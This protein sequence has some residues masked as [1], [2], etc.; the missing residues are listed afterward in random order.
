MTI[1]TG[2]V[3]QDADAWIKDIPEH[4][5]IS[6]D[7]KGGWM[8]RYPPFQQS[9]IKAI[10]SRGLADD[11]LKAFVMIENGMRDVLSIKSPTKIAQAVKK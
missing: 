10:E 3:L 5:F 2:I 4:V 9:W 1:T 6:P 7:R 11:I 8:V